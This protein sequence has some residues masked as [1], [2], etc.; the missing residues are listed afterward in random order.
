MARVHIRCEKCGTPLGS[1]P[2]LEEM[3]GKVPATYRSTIKLLLGATGTA[4]IEAAF[5]SAVRC[6]TCSH[7]VSE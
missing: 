1:M 6:L 3:L 7:F 5:A 4:D 2:G